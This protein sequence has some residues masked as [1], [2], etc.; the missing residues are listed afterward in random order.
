MFLAAYRKAVR[1]ANLLAIDRALQIM[2]R[3]ARLLGLDQP[4]KA[5]LTGQDG[6][7]IELAADATA[8]ELAAL[9]AFT[10]LA[11]RGDQ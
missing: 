10:D 1:D 11:A 3:R 7:S 6:G 4:V 9:I 5:E 8:D 2:E